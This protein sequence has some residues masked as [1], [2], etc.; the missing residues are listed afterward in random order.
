MNRWLAHEP[1]RHLA[2]APD[3]FVDPDGLWRRPMTLD[4][5]E[6]GEVLSGGC[7]PGPLHPAKERSAVASGRLRVVPVF[8]LERP[9]R[10]VPGVHPGRHRVQ[11]RGKVEV[12]PRGC[13][14]LSPCLRIGLER[15]RG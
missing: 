8:A 9:D 6:P 4:P 1:Y 7:D 15:R 3:G 2:L 14:L 13:E 12:H 5:A 11:D 10:L